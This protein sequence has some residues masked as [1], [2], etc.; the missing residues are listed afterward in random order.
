M[1][2]LHSQTGPFTV[3]RIGRSLYRLQGLKG[4]GFVQCLDVRGRNLGSRVVIA[5]QGPVDLDL[6]TFATGIYVIQV[7]GQGAVRVMH[8]Q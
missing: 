3:E 7:V 5:N 6:R 2:E 4:S 8:E 1:E